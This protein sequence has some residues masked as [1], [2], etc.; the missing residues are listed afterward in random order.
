MDPKKKR[1]VLLLGAAVLAGFALKLCSGRAEGGRPGIA[2]ASSA[3][4]GAEPNSPF[5]LP[6]GPNAGELFLKMM[7]AVVLIV[8]LGVGLVYVSKR[9]LPK[10]GAAPGR[11]IQITE[12]VPLGTRKALHLVEVGGRKVLI[13]STAERITMLADV[14]DGFLEGDEVG[15]KG[16]QETV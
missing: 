7:G 14:S 16:G 3:A 2:A 12:T 13:G 5:D 1:I 4:W 15:E 11:R 9:F 10:M 8:A 6:P